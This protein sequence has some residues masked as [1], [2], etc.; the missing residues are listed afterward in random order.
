[1]GSMA[2]AT[3][4]ALGVTGDVGDGDGDDDNSGKDWGTAQGT[5]TRTV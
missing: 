4:R 2:E 5:G 1:M 3:A